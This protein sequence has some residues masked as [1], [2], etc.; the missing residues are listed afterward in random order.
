MV[1]VTK[2][3]VTSLLKSI[4]LF[5]AFLMQF[6]MHAILKYKCVLSTNLTWIKSDPSDP[7]NSNDLDNLDDLTWLQQ[8]HVVPIIS[9][10]ALTFFYN[11]ICLL[12]KNS[13]HSSSFVFIK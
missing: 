13:M 1:A 7:I 3:L 11:F 8:C 5:Q 4:D 12:F 10:E 2:I 9:M 6:S